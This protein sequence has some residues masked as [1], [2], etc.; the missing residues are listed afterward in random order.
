MLIVGTNQPEAIRENTHVRYSLAKL[1]EQ[2]DLYV[3][4]AQQPIQYLEYR[5]KPGDTLSFILSQFYDVN[6]GSSE[7]K[8]RA[9]GIMEL[10]PHISNPDRITAGDLLVLEAS[11]G[12]QM[13]LAPQEN[14]PKLFKAPAPQILSSVPRDSDSDFYALS[15]LAS[16]AN[17]LTLPGSVALGGQGNLLSGGNLGLID[18]V[19]ELYA[20]YK[21]G[22]L[23]KNQYDYQRKLTLDQFRKNIGPFEKLLYGEKTPHEV[24]RIARGGGVPATANITANTQQLKKLAAMAK[25][26]G[27]VLTGVGVAASCVQIADADSSKK[28]NEIFIETLAST[29]IGAAGSYA[30]GLF[31]ISN[32]VGWGT[33]IVLAAGTVAA[34]YLAGKGARAA[35]DL[36]G[37]KVDFVSGTGVGSICRR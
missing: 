33:A 37:A 20:D 7:Y 32:P 5:V 6:F 13:C 18:K 14:Q 12:P 21:S 17:Y 10:N 4:V 3:S 22:K 34:G 9:A 28:K 36:T 19:S 30:V 26:G 2:K 8:R 1:I 35:Y 15:W 24:V 11:A 27:I 16:N 23:T 29:T 25:H 31:L